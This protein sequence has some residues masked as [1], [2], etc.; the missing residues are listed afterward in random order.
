MTVKDPE[1]VETNPDA[2][3]SYEETADFGKYI[4]RAFSNEP[5]FGDTAKEISSPIRVLNT[6]VVSVENSD[7]TTELRYI[8][9]EDARIFGRKLA[10]LFNV[11]SLLG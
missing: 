8:N 10:L 4:V 2:V 7:G 1:T 6:G 9:E 5:L 11:P 3:E